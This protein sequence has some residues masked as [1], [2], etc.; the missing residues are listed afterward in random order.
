MLRS[1]VKQTP[2][3]FPQIAQ[4]KQLKTTSDHLLSQKRGHKRRHCI[5]KSQLLR[6]TLENLQNRRLRLKMATQSGRTESETI[7]V[8]STTSPTM[9]QISPTVSPFSTSTTATTELSTRTNYNILVFG[10][11]PNTTEIL[12]ST[13]PSTTPS[14]TTTTSTT[15]ESTRKTTQTTTVAK[16]SRFVNPWSPCKV[17]LVPRFAI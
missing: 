2:E 9:S 1:D 15:P 5:S 16:T 7:P 8:S 6:L 13:T 12:P 11:L 4:K 10:K 17:V 14:K 3:F